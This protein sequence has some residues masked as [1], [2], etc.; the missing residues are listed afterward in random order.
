MP[1]KKQLQK[2]LYFSRPEIKDFLERY[3]SDESEMTSSS[4]SYLMETH[5][6]HDILPESRDA[7]QKIMDL[8]SMPDGKAIGRVMESIYD[9]FAADLMSKTACSEVRELV[10]FH[11]MDVVLRPYNDIIRTD[12]NIND[13]D[14]VNAREYY[15]LSMKRFTAVLKEHLEMHPDMKE[16][17]YQTYIK[18]EQDIHELEHIM[19]MD[20]DEDKVIY[21]DSLN[22]VFMVILKY[23]DS[24]STYT[25]TYRLLVAICRIHTWITDAQTRLKLVDILKKLSLNW[26]NDSKEK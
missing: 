14:Y 16:T 9:I 21:A 26:D 10:S 7:A 24:I 12:D 2:I 20:G 13:N 19:S 23:W 25:Y 11:Y 17:D 4:T 15:F 6:L 3:M 5:M 22:F 18:M 1:Y 8:Y